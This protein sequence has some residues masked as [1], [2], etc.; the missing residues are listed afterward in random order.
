MTKTRHRRGVDLPLLDAVRNAGGGVLQEPGGV[1]RRP[2]EYLRNSWTRNTFSKNFNQRNLLKDPSGPDLR[3]GEVCHIIGK[4]KV[5][6]KVGR[7]WKQ[8]PHLQAEKGR[9]QL[10]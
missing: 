5:E 7:R 2:E 6:E 8:S 10:H 4:V 3:S 9:I 1:E